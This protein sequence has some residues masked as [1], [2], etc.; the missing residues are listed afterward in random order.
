MPEV[1]IAGLDEADPVVLL[2]YDPDHA[3][4]RGC[5]AE[6]DLTDGRLTARNALVI[7]GVEPLEVQ[8]GVRRWWPMPCLTAAAANRMLEAIAPL[9]QRVLDGASVAP[10]GDHDAGVLDEDARTASEAIAEHLAGE[11]PAQDVVT[12]MDA[13]AWF[14]ED[15]QPS[16]LTADTT[17]AQLVELAGQLERDVA[18]GLYQ[19]YVGEPTDGYVNR[20]IV[21]HDTEEY[22]RARREQLRDEERT[23]LVTLTTWIAQLTGQSDEAVRRQAKWGDTHRDVG[24]RIQRS[25][26]TV[27]NII[28]KLGRDE[29]VLDPQKDGLGLRDWIGKA[30]ARFREEAGIVHVPQY[31]ATLLANKASGAPPQLGAHERAALEDGLR[32]GRQ[33]KLISDTDVAEFLDYLAREPAVVG[34]GIPPACGDAP[35]ADPGTELAPGVSP[36]TGDDD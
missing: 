32:L 15:S 8:R 29:R 3:R 13:G 19:R 22:F 12:G 4:P 21:L 33:E 14:G 30:I 7:D 20:H 5:V 10:D 2:R 26:T 23:A 9:A 27:Q 16:G 35:A 17:D 18:A 28:A 24:E 11:V 1:G 31:L 36:G 34:S 6:L 25:Q